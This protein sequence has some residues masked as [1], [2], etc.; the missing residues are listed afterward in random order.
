MAQAP[1][2]VV[3]PDNTYP[4]GT[5]TTPTVS[6]EKQDSTLVITVSRT[7]LP[8]VPQDLARVRLDLSLDGSIWSPTPSGQ[9]NWLWGD[10]PIFF[11]LGGGTLLDFNGNVI[12]ESKVTRLLPGVGAVGR[13][14]RAT[15]DLFQAIRTT[16]T[17]VIS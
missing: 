16:V 11:T 14:M 8:N 3:L 15:I 4:A 9:T 12:T 13:K 2:T 10:F 17:V 7:N 1:G 5:Y 6:L